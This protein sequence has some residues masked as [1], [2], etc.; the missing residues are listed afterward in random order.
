[1][2]Y[3]HAWSNAW[4]IFAAYAL[5]VAVLFIFLF[6]YKHNPTAPAS[7]AQLKDLASE[8]DDPAGDII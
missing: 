5:V 4:L 6:K 7:K 8:S 1:M 3:A 2:S